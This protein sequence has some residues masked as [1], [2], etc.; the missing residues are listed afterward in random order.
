[1]A[2]ENAAVTPE[3]APPVVRTI[4]EA[5]RTE[6][7]YWRDL[8]R[9]RELMFFLAWRDVSVRYKQTVMGVAWAVVRPLL[10][11]IIMVIVFSKVAKLDSGG[12]PYTLL[13][14]TGMLCWQLFSAGLSSTADSLLG[15]SNLISKVY[16]PRLVIP[17]SS[18]AVSLVDFLVT[19]PILA[20]LMLW[21][22]EAPT[23]RMVLFP[24]FVLLTMLS[25]LSL[26]L[27]MCA[28]N[29]RYRDVRYVLP[30]MIQFGVYVSPVGYAL[31]AVPE[32]YRLW[33]ALNPL[34][35]VIEGF[36][37]SLLAGAP[38]PTPEALAVSLLVP[39]VLL[40][41]GI[42]YFRGT[43]RSFADVI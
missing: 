34:T 11:M 3:T 35:G 41:T 26:G 33:F 42:R 21:Y 9:Y 40:F 28:L 29:V 7:Q 10:T 43:E 15:S 32:A 19:L 8:W 20:A 4:I 24:G 25:A 13:V 17:L 27:W 37:W 31:S 39:A 18:L 6:R 22:G 23:W 2:I 12:V 5:G 36:R 14:L 16:F 1:M 38:A 30:F